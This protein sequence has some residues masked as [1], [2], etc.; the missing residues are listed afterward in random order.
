MLGGIHGRLPLSVS[1][2]LAENEILDGHAGKG[3]QGFDL[4][5]LFGI[6]FDGKTVHTPK[7]DNFYHIVNQ[8]KLRQYSRAMRPRSTD[9]PLLL[10]LDS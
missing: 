3:R 10:N 1:K 2:R 7:V 9:T 4:T 5:M 8:T 6:D